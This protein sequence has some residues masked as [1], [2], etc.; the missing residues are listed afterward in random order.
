MRIYCAKITI[1]N[2]IRNKIA[3]KI[4]G[5]QQNVKKCVRA[6]FASPEAARL[7]PRRLRAAVPRVCRVGL[8]WQGRA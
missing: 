6:N 4:A 5:L 2:D 3:K 1:V 8:G 7:L